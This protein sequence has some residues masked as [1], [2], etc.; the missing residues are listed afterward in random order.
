M[1]FKKFNKIIVQ[2]LRRQE[3]AEFCRKKRV[4][5]SYIHFGRTLARIISVKCGQFARILRRLRQSM[6]AK[7]RELDLSISSKYGIKLGSVFLK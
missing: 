3:N 7:G 2:G 1:Q 6:A 5:I 4:N